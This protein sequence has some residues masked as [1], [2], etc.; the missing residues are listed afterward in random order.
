MACDV[1][2]RRGAI[3]QP[4]VRDRNWTDPSAS[5]HDACKQLVVGFRTGIEGVG[6]ERFGL[7]PARQLDAIQPHESIIGADQHDRER[8]P[9]GLRRSFELEGHRTGE[10]PAAADA[11]HGRGAD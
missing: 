8:K 7:E 4:V 3:V 9:I 11:P 6:V 5:T 2:T 10:R 1:V